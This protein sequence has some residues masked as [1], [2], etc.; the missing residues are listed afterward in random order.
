MEDNRCSAFLGRE[1]RWGATE[2]ER[3]RESKSQETFL[4]KR[5]L[6]SFLTKNV[7]ADIA[8]VSESGRQTM[9]ALS[10]RIARDTF[11]TGSCCEHN[12]VFSQTLV[13]RLMLAKMTILKKERKRR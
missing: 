13:K 12:P 2:R 3:E 10:L 6:H 7:C 9:P 4:A 11:L 1:W 5:Y 8:K